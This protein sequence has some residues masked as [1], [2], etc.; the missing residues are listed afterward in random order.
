MNCSHAFPE[1]SLCR[2]QVNHDFTQEA[3]LQ[4]RLQRLACSRRPQIP[5]RLRQVETC[6]GLLPRQQMRSLEMEEA[7]GQGDCT[8]VRYRTRV[9]PT[10]TMSCQRPDN[11]AASSQHRAHSRT[12][13]MTVLLL[14]DKPAAVL[15]A[16]FACRKR[17]VAAMHRAPF[18]Q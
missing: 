1:Q 5:Q 9:C 11:R 14:Q 15:I 4:M 2:E 18:S 6:S 17:E 12:R 16:Q 13:N 8:A 3:V 7:M 10:H